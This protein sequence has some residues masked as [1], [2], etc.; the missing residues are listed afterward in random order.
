MPPSALFCSLCSHSKQ[1]DIQLKQHTNN[2]IVPVRCTSPAEA[3]RQW[4]WKPLNLLLITSTTSPRAAKQQRQHS[5]SVQLCLLMLLQ[6]NNNNM[7]TARLPPNRCSANICTRPAV[8]VE[9]DGGMD[10]HL[11]RTHI[12]TPV[13]CLF[14]CSLPSQCILRI[15]PISPHAKLSQ[16][17]IDVLPFFYCLE[18]IL[19]IFTVS[20]FV[21]RRSS[22]LNRLTL[23]GSETQEQLWN[24]RKNML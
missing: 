20:A 2:A 3:R 5:V 18:F 19:F 7:V 10:F 16:A 9:K 13:S 21:P 1:N 6:K 8:R 11:T 22:F 24:W 12:N 17:V 23:K 4:G 14:L 15:K